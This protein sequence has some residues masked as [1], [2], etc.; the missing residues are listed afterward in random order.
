MKTCRTIIIISILIAMPLVGPSLTSCGGEGGEGVSGE[1]A[2][3]SMPD[4]AAIKTAISTNN[5]I[6]LIPGFALGTITLPECTAVNVDEI[7]YTVTN[8]PAWLTFDAATRTLALSS[9]NE[10]PAEA[11]TKA[12]ITYTCTSSADDSVTDSI[13]FMVND[14]DGGGA[15]DGSEYFFG[16]VPLLHPSFGWIWLNPGNVNLYRTP[17]SSPRKIPTGLTVPTAGMDPT[18]AAD[19]AEDF[20]GDGTTNVDEI[21]NTT[22]LFVATSNGSFSQVEGP[23]T[24][25]GEAIHGIASADFNGDGKTDVVAISD[26]QVAYYQGKGD[27][28]FQDPV[29]S[30]LSVGTAEFMATADF[31]GDGDFDIVTEKPGPPDKIL[32]LVND[33][34]GTFSQSDSEDVAAN[35]IQV[36]TADFNNDGMVDL[37]VSHEGNANVSIFLGKGDGTLQGENLR[38]AG[39]EQ[40]GLAAADLDR[41]GNMDLAAAARTKAIILKGKGDGTFNTPDT[42]NFADASSISLRITAADVDNDGDV[43]LIAS[44]RNT[45]KVHALI[46]DGSGTFNELGTTDVGKDAMG[47]IALDVDGDGMVDVAVAN[48]GDDN[49]GVLRGKGDG[50]FSNYAEYIL[51]SFISPPGKGDPR[52]LT[53]GDIDNDGDMDIVTG[54]LTSTWELYIFRNQ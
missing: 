33:G 47:V 21:D 36:V 52:D 51:E 22:D 26:S 42:V 7:V 48:E 2:S 54:P 8:L 14:L 16:N 28:T 10:I 39:S 35:G 19:E 43:D 25:G 41:D 11:S 49:I 24:Q 5:S 44:D 32:I 30:I 3:L 17:E 31:D 4:A 53:A 12:E 1:T 34:S 20:D 15:S 40:F 29:S 6:G 9:G 27:A 23:M 38:D 50:T 46:N 13:T 45:S 18:N 37:A